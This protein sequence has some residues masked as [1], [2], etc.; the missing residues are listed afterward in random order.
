[1]VH[2]IADIARALGL[3]AEGALDLIVTRVAEPAAATPEALALAMDPKYAEGLSNGQARAAILWPGA[4]WRAF[5]LEAAIFAPRPRWAMAGVSQVMDP[6]YEFGVGVHPMAYIDPTAQVA[7]GARIGPFATVGAHS[8]IGPGARIGANASIAEDVV[9]GADL[10]LHAGARIAARCVI[11]ERFI[12]Q[13][14][15][16]VGGCG[17]SFVTPEPSAAEDVRATL[18]GTR[19]IRQQ[20]WQRINSLG[21]VR[22]GDDVE[23][24]AN[25]SI[26]RGTVRDTVIGSGSK[27]DSLCQIGHNV[28]MGEDC[29]MCGM[30]GIAGSARIGNRVLLAGKSA[31]NDNIFVG[32]DVIVGGAA[33][34]FTNVP[35]GR[36]ILGDPATKIETQ[37]EIRKALRRLPR[38]AATVAEL[39]KAIRGQK[40]S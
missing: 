16:V 18:S 27:I 22:I 30:A 6:G 7:E 31:V 4:D 25:S 39:Q 12:G 28:Q 1:M 23:L 34:V 26:D 37:L 11:G 32:D 21:A 13:P 38:L 20:K 19:E 36:A 2:S 35:S 8:Q 5:G 10:T 40:D 15:S 9:I 33:R 14:N 29:M 3:Q 17:F 24:G